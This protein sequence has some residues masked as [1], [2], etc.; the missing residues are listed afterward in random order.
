MAG[1]VDGASASFIDC[2]MYNVHVVI[3]IF[4]I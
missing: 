4:F 1:D 3:I 2:S